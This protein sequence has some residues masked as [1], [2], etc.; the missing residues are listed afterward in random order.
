MSEVKLNA[1]HIQVA[2]EMLGMK[3]KKMFGMQ[4]QYRHGFGISNFWTLEEVGLVTSYD[5]GD[6]WGRKKYG[7]SK[8]ARKILDDLEK[9]CCLLKDDK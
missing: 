2:K 1:R 3:P 8:N 4:W 6:P 9:N 5:V 7:I